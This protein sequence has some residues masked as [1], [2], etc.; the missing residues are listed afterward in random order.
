M[1]RPPA[2]EY[3]DIPTLGEPE[4]YIHFTEGLIDAQG[5]VS[6]EGDSKVPSGFVDRYAAWI[7]R[8]ATA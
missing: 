4:V 5:S 2:G 1:I 7:Q 6:N 3:L 8:F